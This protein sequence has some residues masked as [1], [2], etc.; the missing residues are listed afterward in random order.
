MSGTLPIIIIFLSAKE[1][2]VAEKGDEG[3]SR[4][5]N[6]IGRTFAIIRSER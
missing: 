1:G 3:D 6:G 5:S 4:H 2:V